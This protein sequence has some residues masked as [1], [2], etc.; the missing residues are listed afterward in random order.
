MCLANVPYV[1]HDF[2]DLLKC[3]PPFLVPTARRSYSAATDKPLSSA[4]DGADGIKSSS[5]FWVF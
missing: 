1:C 3:L 5:S 4:A 2:Y